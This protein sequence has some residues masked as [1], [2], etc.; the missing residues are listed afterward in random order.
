[1]QY[2]NHFPIR[3]MLVA[4]GLLL[5]LDVSAQP[6]VDEIVHRANLA[7][8]YQGKDGRAQVQMTIT[9]KQG[10]DRERR[11]IILRRDESDTDALKDNAYW[12]EQK[13]Y[14]YFQRPSDLNRTVFMV[15]KHLESDDDRWLY[16]PSL[17]L[18]RRISATDK[19]NSFVGSDF[20]YEDVSGRNIDLDTHELIDT[21]DDYYVVKSTPKRPEEVEFAWYESYIHTDS[22]IPVQI[23]YYKEGGEKYREATA[24]KVE[25]IDGYPTVTNSRMKSLETGST[26][27]MEYL[28]VEYDVGLPEDIFTE[29]YLRRAPREH[30]R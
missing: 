18:V 5:T 9:D 29:R 26:T 10:R 14:V 25:T 1:M 12:G 28:S 27:T 11:M 24:L 7:A 30:L 21:T 8:Y 3:A 4:A 13:Y 6:S 23:S 22:F 16:L 15:W 20:F 19:R 17:D 2:P